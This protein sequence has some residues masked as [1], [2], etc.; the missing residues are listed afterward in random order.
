M[1]AHLGQHRGLVARART[2]LEHVRAG[3]HLERLAHECDHVGL[4]DRLPLANRQGG[5]LVGAIAERRLDEKMARHLPHGGEHGRV[6]EAPRLEL[7][8]DHAAA[9]V[10]E[11]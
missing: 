11:V 9:G 5:V 10:L 3:R 8:L 7:L 6:A 2:D 4:R 1:R